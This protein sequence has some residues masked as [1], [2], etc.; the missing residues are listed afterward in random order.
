MLNLCLNTSPNHVSFGK[1]SSFC[2]RWHPASLHRL[3]RENR[4][5]SHSPSFLGKGIQI[6]MEAEQSLNIFRYTVGL[7]KNWML[8]QIF[9]CSH[10]SFENQT[11]SLL[12]Q[13]IYLRNITLKKDSMRQFSL[14]R[15]QG[16]GHGHGQGDVRCQRQHSGTK[17]GMM[18]MF[19]FGLNVNVNLYRWGTSFRMT[20]TEHMKNIFRSV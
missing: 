9:N 10:F 18:I 16:R 4:F 8:V 12:N 14:E 2:G 15:G 5:L 17:S 3:R 7:V 11:F 13:N 19:C 6:L 1:N 20:S